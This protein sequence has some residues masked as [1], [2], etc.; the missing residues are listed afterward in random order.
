M[1]QHPAIF[2]FRVFVLFSEFS[3]MSPDN[4]RW[5]NPVRLQYQR[6]M[7]IFFLSRIFGVE[8]ESGNPQLSKSKPWLAEGPKAPR[9]C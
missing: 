8:A 6:S 3:V 9:L 2:F 5:K 1:G 4:M 7:F